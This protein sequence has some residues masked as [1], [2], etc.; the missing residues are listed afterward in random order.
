[1]P[2]RA[3][4]AT[5][6]SYAA[7]DV[8]GQL[9]YC[10]VM[11][12]VPYFYTD[13]CKIPAAGVAA[14]LL[15]TRFLDAIDAPLWGILVDRTRS[16]WGKSRPWFLRLC[17]P[18]ATFGVLAFLVPD[19]GYKAKLGYAAVTYAACNILFT[20]INT[21][22]TSILPAL[23]ADPKERLVLTTF[24]MLGSKLGVLVVNLTGLALVRCLGRGNDR[25]G[26]AL[27]VPIFAAFSVALFL[28]AFR[29]LKETAL[30]SRPRSV[31]ATFGAMKGNWPWLIVVIATVLFWIGFISRVT[32]APHFFKYVLHRPDLV[33][34]ANGLD[35]VS[36]ATA[37]P[38]PWL[39]RRMS[40]SRLWALGLAGM[41]L[42]QLILWLGTARGHDMGLCLA[43][44][45]VGFV[46]SG[47]AM[48]LP[49]SM[50]ADT[51][52]YGEWKTGVQAAGLLTAIGSAFCV[53]VGAGLGG[54]L[55]MWLLHLGGYVEGQPQTSAALVALDY[56]IVAIP[57]ICFALALLPALLYG[58]FERL[59]PQIQAALAHRRADCPPPELPGSRPAK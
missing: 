17:L 33:G 1:M 16:K 39:C 53:K 28:I 56:G 29:N 57:A 54:A 45:T 51:V 43:G 32:V 12:Y 41:V 9:L 8:A 44:W 20:G 5:R 18:F 11:W 6:L 59:E 50:L 22:V 23:T 42:G 27:T 15:G 2:K 21:P 3:L 58:R 4:S 48:T 47:A 46:F 13:A 30:P 31:R 7:S 34:L 19:V 36:L 14:I 26:F 10:W 49:F 37:L 52:D 24:R 38:L 40:K 35:V 25:A 55:P